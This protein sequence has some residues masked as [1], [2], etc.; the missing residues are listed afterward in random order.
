MLKVVVIDANAISR[1]LLTSVLVSGGHD[2][3]GDA[4]ASLA[5]IASMI[6]LRPQLV[7][8]D[9]GQADSDGL[10]KLEAVRTGLPKSLVFLVSGKLDPASVQLALE[11]GVHGFIVKPFNGATVLM[12]I[13]NTIVKVAKQHRAAQNTEDSTG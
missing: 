6:K 4:T 12:S 11:R 9:I 7:C 10:E 5:G 8:I 13:R 2:V 1:N 3:V